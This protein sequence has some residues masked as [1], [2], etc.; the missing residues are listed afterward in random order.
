[1]YVVGDRPELV[2]KTLL[3]RGY[4]TNEQDAFTLLARKMNKPLEEQELIMLRQLCKWADFETV[5][6]IVFGVSAYDFA[7]AREWLEL[8]AMPFNPGFPTSSEDREFLSGINSSHATDYVCGS[9]MG[10]V[11]VAEYLTEEENLSYTAGILAII[12]TF[13][14]QILVDATDY[15]DSSRTQ[16]NQ[17]QGN[18]TNAI[19]HLIRGHKPKFDD[20]YVNWRLKLVSEIFSLVDMQKP[21]KLTKIGEFLLEQIAYAAFGLFKPRDKMKALSL[22]ITS[23][24]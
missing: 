15:S 16:F 12:I 23:K 18:L 4:L 13:K 9:I 8:I 2:E 24:K 6:R 14:I 17:M 3:E 19:H 5:W 21:E 11:K 10:I 7:N 20:W 1:M 22:L